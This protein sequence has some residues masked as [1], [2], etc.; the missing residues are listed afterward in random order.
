MAERT[1]R[2]IKPKQFHGEVLSY[3]V[4]IRR[5]MESENSKR[6]VKRKHFFDELYQGFSPTAAAKSSPLFSSSQQKRHKGNTCS[7]YRGSKTKNEDDK[8]DNNNSSKKSKASKTSEYS[9]IRNDEKSNP[10]NRIYERLQNLQ[11]QKSP[12]VPDMD[13]AFFL[14]C[15]SDSNRPDDDGNKVWMCRFE[16]RLKDPAR[17]GRSGQLIASC[18]GKIICLVDS[19]SGRVMMRY[20]DSDKDENFYAMAWTTLEIAGDKNRDPQLTNI[21]A[22]AGEGRR[23]KLLHPSQLV[24]Y[25]NI[26]GHKKCITCLLFHPSRATWLFSGSDDCRIILWDIGVPS[27]PDYSTKHLQL[28][29]LESPANVV[30]MVYS[31]ATSLLLAGTE[32]GCFG[33]KFKDSRANICGKSRKPLARFCLPQ[34]TNSSDECI[35]G[36]VL[37]DDNTVASKCVEEKYI[38]LWNLTDHAP[39]A[40]ALNSSSKTRR[41]EVNPFTCLKYQVMD[42]PYIYMSGGKDRLVVGDAEG[43]IFIYNLKHVLGK[44]SSKGDNPNLTI[45]KGGNLL[46]LPSRVLDW[47]KIEYNCDGNGEKRT[48]EEAAM[49]NDDGSR[50]EE[51]EEEEEERPIINS[52][53]MDDKGEVLAATADCNLVCI[54]KVCTN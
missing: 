1:K 53:V 50:K 38:Y 2:S 26:T 43:R 17:S 28:I 22:V 39:P 14:R 25:A 45:S 19:G 48:E 10:Q 34:L 6:V 20:K 31:R 54:W 4:N 30:N 16:P 32:D 21:L 11:L 46:H 13:P 33:W 24:I 44:S 40:T 27:F 8:P 47:P 42:E 37:V 23:I 41:I 9:N 18:G 36:L 51:D 35:D 5:N 12:A 52:V 3:S 15:H 7:D 49:G 29:V